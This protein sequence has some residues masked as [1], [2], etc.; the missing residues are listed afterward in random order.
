MLYIYETI[1]TRGFESRYLEEHYR[2]LEELAHR[3]VGSPLKISCERLRV[4][5][6]ESL[7]RNNFSPTRNHA[8]I[9]RCHYSGN[10]DIELIPVEMLYD[11]FSVRA[12]RPRVGDTECV[13]K[14]TTLLENCSVKEALLKM[15]RVKRLNLSGDNSVPMWTTEDG[16]VVAI[17]GSSVI[18]VF[19]DEIRFSACG[20]GVEFLLAYNAVV[21]SHRRVTKGAIM[22][23]ELNKAKELLVVDYRGI[24]AI[25]GW[26]THHYLNITAEWIASRVVEAEK[27]ENF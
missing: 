20:D 26:N 6:A 4:E 24:T 21:G 8:V 13:V 3:I 5:I 1:R 25:E 15:H 19:D 16:E 7:R 10:S 12:I 9:V 27:S 17:D 18:A 14:N 11:D 23:A 2:R 22:V